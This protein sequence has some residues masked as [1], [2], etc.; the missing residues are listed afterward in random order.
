MTSCKCSTKHGR[1]SLI[2][3]ILSVT[4]RKPAH[5]IYRAF[6]VVVVVV[7]VIKYLATTQENRTSRFPTRS[8]T[9]RFEQLQKMVRKNKCADQLCSYCTADLLICAFVFA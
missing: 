2:C 6:V 5:A 8:D 7:V 4:I 9:N 1:V 3:V